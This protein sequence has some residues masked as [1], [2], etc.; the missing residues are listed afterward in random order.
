MFGK[1]NA[2]S[3]VDFFSC[4]N[5]KHLA[6]SLCRSAILYLNLHVVR[7][8]FVYG[9]SEYFRALGISIL[10]ANTAA[11]FGKYLNV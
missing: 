11:G 3:Q 2:S 4:K 6:I 5:L 8:G 1:W 10:V 7:L 9:L